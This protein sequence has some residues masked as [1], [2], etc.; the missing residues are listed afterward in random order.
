MALRA[1]LL[2]AV[3]LGPI[4]VI[5]DLRLA[6]WPRII[7]NPRSN[8]DATFTKSTLRES[9][10]VRN[11]GRRRTLP[12]NATYAMYYEPGD[13]GYEGLKK[14]RHKAYDNF[15]RSNIDN[16][17]DRRNIDTEDG[18]DHM[19]FRTWE[20][21]K[22]SPGKHCDI[23]ASHQ[24]KMIPKDANKAY[25][26]RSDIHEYGQDIGTGGRISASAQG[27]NVLYPACLQ[28]CKDNS[29]CNCIVWDPLDGTK[30]RCYLMKTC[31][32]P[33]KNANTAKKG[34]NVRAHLPYL[35]VTPGE[36]VLVPLRWNNPHAAEL[37]VNIW[38]MNTGQAIPI[39]VPVMKPTCSGEGY[40]DQAFTF[41]V[42]TDFNTLRSKVAGF[43][44]CKVVGDCNLHVYAHSVEPRMYSLAVPLVIEGAVT[45]TARNTNS[46]DVKTVD[47]ADLKDPEVVGVEDPNR[48]KICLP[49]SDPSAHWTT[50][51]PQQARLVSDQWNWAYQNNDYSPYAGQQPKIISRNLQAA[52]VVEMLPGNRGTLGVQALARDNRAG[53]RA[54]RQLLRKARKVKREFEKTADGI[55]QLL[56]KKDLHKN[57]D[58]MLN[59]KNTIGETKEQHTEFCFRCSEV[60]SVG[61]KRKNTR[62]YIP[63]FQIADA[64]TRAAVTFLLADEYKS[65]IDDEGYVQIYYAAM[66][67]LM[68]QFREVAKVNIHYQGAVIKQTIDTKPDA[69]NYKRILEDGMTDK[70]DGAAT[71][72][73]LAYR[74]AGRYNKGGRYTKDWCTEGCVPNAPLPSE[75]VRYTPVNAAMAAALAVDC[76]L[77]DP[78]CAS[79]ASGLRNQDQIEGGYA[80]LAPGADPHSLDTDRD[81]DNLEGICTTDDCD[82]PNDKDVS[83]MTCQPSAEIPHLWNYTD[84][85]EELEASETTNANVGVVADVAANQFSTCVVVSMLIFCAIL[86]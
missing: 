22:D 20:G 17:Q 84:V 57:K 2:L 61:I 42:P 55:I 8:D 72:A 34:T 48:R 65:L 4:G 47:H 67:Q 82:G 77:N 76:P 49:R 75:Q 27:D 21:C 45:G 36:E 78:T 60:G 59:A 30:S 63:S 25:A 73:R 85:G 10:M 31:K 1:G 18:K 16:E 38:L 43:K 56:E 81:C 23:H 29:E 19:P 58:I 32:G 5:A 80:V 69:A 86:V 35:Q 62:T 6:S 74:A 46:A 37:E 26:E 50:S 79:I 41:K 68:D 66:W 13:F 54:Q 40:Q 64:Q 7:E 52:V 12:F 15:L 3:L 28:S 70:N 71:A 14:Q 33:K 9:W 39:V 11:Q 24:W 53:F 51:N 44:G 83:E